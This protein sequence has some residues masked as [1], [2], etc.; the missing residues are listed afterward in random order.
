M[1]ILKRRKGVEETW[2]CESSAIHGC[3][4]SCTCE[5]FLDPSY[6]YACVPLSYNSQNI[7]FRVTCYS[8]E[9]VTVAAKSRDGVDDR[10]YLNLLH[11]ELIR[12]LH[13]VHY[14]IASKGLLMCIHGQD[15][16]YFLVLNASP[17]HYLS[18][19]L[20][21]DVKKGMLLAYGQSGDTH[22]IPPRAQKI[23]MV[24]LSDGTDSTAASVTF[25]YVCD[26]VATLNR[27]GSIMK[28]PAGIG[29]VV[30]L[31]IAGDLIAGEVSSDVATS[32][33]CDT[34]ETHHWLSQ[35]GSGH[36]VG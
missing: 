6:D 35:L 21:L 36:T 5:I 13:K 20:T 26:T 19:R 18:V 10:E 8:S 31:S 17:D 32:I 16:L 12:K 9:E 33:G 24:A 25:S 30:D 4:R 14:A 23:L 34:V 15:C 27:S 2:S 29:S 7:P 22:D 28:G 3:T 11:R 1:L